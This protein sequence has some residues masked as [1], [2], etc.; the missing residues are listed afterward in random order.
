MSTKK[1]ELFNTNELE[2]DVSQL[3]CECL[4][5]VWHNASNSRFVQNFNKF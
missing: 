1:L 3:K 5:H 2:L 4:R